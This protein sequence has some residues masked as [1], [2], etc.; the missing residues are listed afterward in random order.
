MANSH[1]VHA[2]ADARSRLHDETRVSSN[3]H[4]VCGGHWASAWGASVT[5]SAAGRP[6]QLEGRMSRKRVT[7][8]AGVVDIQSNLD[9]RNDLHR[10]QCVPVLQTFRS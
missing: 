10:K 4:L 2:I 5:R 7:H 6:A 3:E 8:V 1:E 9:D